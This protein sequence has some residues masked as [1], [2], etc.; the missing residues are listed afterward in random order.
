MS[1]QVLLLAL[2]DPDGWTVEEVLIGPS[3]QNE[4]DLWSEWCETRSEP[5]RREELHFYRN[6]LISSKGFRAPAW[7]ER[8]FQ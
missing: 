5:S 7:S 8:T 1:E 3:D 6:W 2:V 4:H